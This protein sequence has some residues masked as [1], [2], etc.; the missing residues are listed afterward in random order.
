MS[1]EINIGIDISKEKIDVCILPHGEVFVVENGAAGFK[2][3]FKK[4]RTLNIARI[5]FEATGRYH[6]QLEQ[7]LTKQ[8][9][10]FCKINPKNGKR[11]GE[12][13]G[14]LAKT[15]RL[16][17]QMLAQMGALLKP[18]LSKPMAQNI[19]SL[20]ELLVAHRAL[21]KD[22][23]A[24]TL[25]SQQV[26]HKLLKTQF[27][28][29]LAQIIN[30]LKAIMVEMTALVRDDET[31]KQRMDILCTIP[32]I[33]ELSALNLI[34]DM[35]ELGSMNSKQAAKL[36]GL[37]PNTRQSGKWQGHSFIGGG[38]KALRHALYM[39]SLIACRYNKALKVKYD[40]LIQ[41]GKAPKLAIIAI[42]R[43]LITLANTLLKNNTPFQNITA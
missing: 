16:D 12:I 39:P 14:K 7:F 28:Q 21:I 29:K 30:Q 34:I 43:N 31:L 24:T 27:K 38:R 6:R 1:D 18:A 5:V 36:A 9:L 32:G 8:D 40:R 15:D 13:F 17:A 23:V 11:F 33:G 22:K 25:R 4:I 42:M 26:Q 19:D 10:P 20:R 3:L 35:P 37:A 2:E 41:A